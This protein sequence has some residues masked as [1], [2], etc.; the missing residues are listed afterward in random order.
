MKNNSIVTYD[1]IVEA[2]KSIIECSI[3]NDYEN[4]FDYL[5]VKYESSIDNKVDSK[6][7]SILYH[8]LKE[9][10]KS[11]EDSSK[12]IRKALEEQLINDSIIKINC[13]YILG[14]ENRVLSASDDSIEK[15]KEASLDINSLNNV[16]ALS[17]TALDELST[18]DTNKIFSDFEANIINKYPEYFD[19]DIP[20]EDVSYDIEE[21]EYDYEKI[22]MIKKALKKAKQLNDTELVDKLQKM[23]DDEIN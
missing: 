8:S 2:L 3:N 1:E 14:Y 20:L 21:K 5:N 7:E 12:I 11:I 4:D 15:L 10:E 16:P 19:S 13:E 22:E 6:E 17:S 18:V 9:L 23:Y